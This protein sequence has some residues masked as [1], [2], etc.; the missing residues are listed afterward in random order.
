MWKKTNNSI[1]SKIYLAPK[2]LI[3]FLENTKEKGS[4]FKIDMEI[5]INEYTKERN[6]GYKL[7]GMIT[8]FQKDGSEGGYQ[9]Y[10]YSNEFNKWYYLFDEY[11]DEVD[12]FYKYIE[13]TKSVPYILFY[14]NICNNKN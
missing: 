11:V 7:I 8:Y 2:I 14:R 5:D 4:N 1:I 6:E 13:K 9:A 10:C 12:D 3:I